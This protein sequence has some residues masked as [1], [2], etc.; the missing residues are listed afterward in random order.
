MTSPTAS[1]HPTAPS[2]LL[3]YDVSGLN[4]AASV[5]VAHLI[6]GRSDAGPK[7]PQ[8]F[9]ARPGVVWVGQSV[10]LM[11]AALAAELGEKLRGLGAVVTTAYVAIDP[12]QVEALSRRT[13]QRR[14]RKHANGGTAGVGKT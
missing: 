11:P 8:P 5:K 13:A 10:F 1:G 7:S 14:S 6:F 2:A 12:D 4:R 3:S 9:V